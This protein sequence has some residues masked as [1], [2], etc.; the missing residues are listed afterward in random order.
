MPDVASIIES[1]T[2]AAFLSLFVRRCSMRAMTHDDAE[3][4]KGPKAKSA[5][6]VPIRT[7][8]YAALWLHVALIAAAGCGCPSGCETGV[9]GPAPGE[10]PHRP[11][12]LVD[13][14]LHH[15]YRNFQQV[16]C[17]GNCQIAV[18]S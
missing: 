16:G 1:S 15:S 11:A 6:P 10:A 13:F 12:D 7:A 18:V 8:V 4:Q 5:S 3:L 17:R 9:R 14:L 2:G